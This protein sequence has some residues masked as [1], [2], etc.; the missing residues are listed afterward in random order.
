[1]ILASTITTTDSYLLY[2]RFVYR[3]RCLRP[4]CPRVT[5]RPNGRI[6]FERRECLRKDHHIVSIGTL[7]RMQWLA[8]IHPASSQAPLQHHGH[9]EL[10]QGTSETVVFF[11]P[12]EFPSN[13]SC[14]KLAEARRGRAMEDLSSFHWIRCGKCRNPF[15]TPA[16]TA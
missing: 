10:L 1:M 14:P 3:I 9:S 8:G 11:T 16:L 13:L 12:S 5:M 2:P 7:P 6:K 15:L 4:L